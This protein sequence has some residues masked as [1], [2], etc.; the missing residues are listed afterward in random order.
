LSRWPHRADR[1]ATAA[2]SRDPSRLPGR[3]GAG[4]GRG[5]RARGRRVWRPASPGRP[6]M[7]GGFV[8]AAEM[9]GEVCI[10]VG[11]DEHGE[12]RAKR[13]NERVMRQQVTY[14][15]DHE[16]TRIC[17]RRSMTRRVATRRACHD[18]R[19]ALARASGH[20]AAAAVTRGVGSGSEA[21]ARCPKDA[22]ISAPL[23]DRFRYVQSQLLH[24][25]RPGPMTRV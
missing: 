20:V 23:R 6:L 2:A 18:C 24:G 5:A 25:T 22:K 7:G 10:S 16:L 15:R 14:P 19:A 12:G 17:S 3:G 8:V 13:C 4:A 9:R 1:D 21:P 11:S